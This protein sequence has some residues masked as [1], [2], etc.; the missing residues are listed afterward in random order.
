MILNRLR[1]Q[2]VLLELAGEEHEQSKRDTGSSHADDDKAE[3]QRTYIEK[4][5]REPAAIEDR[6]GVKQNSR[7][8]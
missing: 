4:R 1:N 2:R 8:R 6:A 3:D 7:L 5:L